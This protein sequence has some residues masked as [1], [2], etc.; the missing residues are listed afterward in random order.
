MTHSSC[1]TPHAWLDLQGPY[2]DETV[3]CRQI[4]VG[5]QAATARGGAGHPNQQRMRANGGGGADRDARA[6]HERL[7]GSPL[8]RCSALVTA[9]PVAIADALAVADFQ[10]NRVAAV[11]GDPRGPEEVDP[12]C[13]ARRWVLFEELV[14]DQVNRIAEASWASDVAQR[15]RTPRPDAWIEPRPAEPAIE[16]LRQGLR[17]PDGGLGLG[18]RAGLVNAQLGLTADGDHTH[19]GVFGRDPPTWRLDLVLDVLRDQ[20][21]AGVRRAPPAS[22]GVPVGDLRILI[23]VERAGQPTVL[24]Q[25]ADRLPARRVGESE[26]FLARHLVG[27]DR[28]EREARQQVTTHQLRRRLQVDRRKV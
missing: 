24:V 26:S 3:P 6:L 9:R 1:L 4:A 12:H 21:V 23:G 7:P 18:R 27:Q 28:V 19:S 15:E 14:A 22:P 17:G 11:C 16:T 2:L 13:P 10:V 8:L 5:R 25:N 20:V